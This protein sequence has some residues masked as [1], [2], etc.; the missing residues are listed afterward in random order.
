MELFKRKII[1]SKTKRKRRLRPL[2]NMKPKKRIN[3]YMVLLVAFL[4]FVGFRVIHFEI[5]FN[6]LAKEG[7]VTRGYIDKFIS[8]GT[9]GC[10]IY[11]FYYPDKRYKRTGNCGFGTP[12]DSI[13]VVFLP[14]KP[15]INEPW[16]RI[17][18][19]KKAQERIIRRE[20]PE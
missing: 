5:R 4:F 13:D 1:M 10:S 14:N 18:K 12:G 9:G 6:N 20:L 15:E 8:A 2:K 19:R 7:V 3:L 17:K 16:A 11:H